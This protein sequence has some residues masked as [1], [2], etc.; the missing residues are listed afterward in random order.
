[1]NR[2]YYR[3]EDATQKQGISNNNIDV[4]AFLENY[5]QERGKWTSEKIFRLWGETGLRLAE[6]SIKK[7]VYLCEKNGIE[8]TIA[9]YPWPFQI[10]NG[11]LDSIQVRFWE[12]FAK[13]NGVGFIN[14][15]PVFINGLNPEDT[16]RKYF[17][18]EDVHWNDKGHE[19][20]ADKQ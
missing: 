7:L 19:L 2:I 11:E 15:F 4:D 9:V 17:I 13:E 18:T 10:M 8:A 1:M 3:S 14:Y 6:I 20:I 16:I 5:Y 12:T